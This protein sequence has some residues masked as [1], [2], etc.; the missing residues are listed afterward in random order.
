L[1]DDIFCYTFYEKAVDIALTYE[2]SQKQLQTMNIGED[3]KCKQYKQKENVRMLQHTVLINRNMNKVPNPNLKL[4]YVRGVAM[5]IIS[6]MHKSY[7][8]TVTN[9]SD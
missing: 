3:P 7:P 4:N 1:Q 9:T 6:K 5:I 8:C 2:L